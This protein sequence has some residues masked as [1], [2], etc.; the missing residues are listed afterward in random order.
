ANPNVGRTETFHRLNRGEYTNAVRDLLDLDIDPAWLPGD[1]S[2]FGFDNIAGVEKM[3][4]VLMER[5]QTEAQKVGRLAVGSLSIPMSESVFRLT[6]DVNQDV[7]FDGL[8]LG[9]RGG[10]A[11]RYQFPLDAEY[12]I[13]LEV[14]RDGND[15]VPIYNDPHVLEVSV[16][17]ER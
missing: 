17:G 13:R 4:P 16:D 11:V 15:F 6:S 5:Y 10:M 3:S 1:E 7:H 12:E 9:T 8:P 2:S 14:L